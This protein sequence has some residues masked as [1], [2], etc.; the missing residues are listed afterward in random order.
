MG[1]VGTLERGRPRG[2]QGRGAPTGAAIPSPYTWKHPQAGA[3]GACAGSPGWGPPTAGAPSSPP[4]ASSSRSENRA[5][6]GS[7]TS[8]ECWRG[9]HPACC[10]AASPRS[11]ASFWVS[12]GHRGGGAQ[13]HGGHS[14]S[15]G[16][17]GG[18]HRDV[19][20]AAGTVHPWAWCTR[21]VQWMWAHGAMGMGGGYV[22]G[23]LMPGTRRRPLLHA[24][25]PHLRPHG[26]RG[27]RLRLSPPNVGV[28]RPVGARCPAA[29]GTER[30][31]GGE[32]GVPL[33]GR[34]GTE[35][36]GARV[37]MG[38]ATGWA[39]GAHGSEDAQDGWWGA[40]GYEGVQ[41]LAWGDVRVPRVG[42]G[43]PWGTSVP[44]VP[45]VDTRWGG[46]AQGG[47]GVG[48]GSPNP[49]GCPERARGAH[50][51]KGLWDCRGVPTHGCRGGQRTTPPRPAAGV[52]CRDPCRPVAARRPAAST[53]AAAAGWARGVRRDRVPAC[54]A[55]CCTATTPR[56][57]CTAWCDPSW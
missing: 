21:W 4:P 48:T 51:P 46:G 43:W 54:C 9:W 15:T 19:A 34:V 7:S 37:G 50:T 17:E 18:G 56:C 40:R 30:G 16:S 47:Y 11:S 22:A 20:P 25:R 44:E 27:H 33:P 36:E 14:R 52:P 32:H 10:S 57:C 29:G 28:R 26:R 13:G 45:W 31:D 53:S 24:R 55:H 39:G 41:G 49:L 3:V 42:M 5:R 6:R 23:V 2:A 35:W 1:Q 8:G 12:G 38:W